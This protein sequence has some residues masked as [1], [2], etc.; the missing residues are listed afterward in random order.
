MIDGRFFRMWQVKNRTH[1]TIK[2]GWIRGRQGEEI[3]TV[4]LK[5]TFDILPDGTTRL[6]S[7][8]LPVNAGPVLNSDNETLLYDVDLGAVKN[9]TDIIL[10]G[11]AVSPNGNKVT[12]VL[13]GL[14]VGKIFRLARVY[15]DR[16]WD[17][18]RY[19]EPEPFNRMSN[20]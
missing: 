8:Q 15:G 16:I 6:A 3:W 5:V 9:A 4:A 18:K 12:S 14:R 19:R 2:H 17:G 7:S 13:V 1:Y 10:N 11:H 20:K